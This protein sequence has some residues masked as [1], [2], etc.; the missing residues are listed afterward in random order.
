M[1]LRELNSLQDGFFGCIHTISN[2]SAFIS[3]FNGFDYG[4]AR[5]ERGREDPRHTRQTEGVDDPCG[6][7]V[8]SDGGASDYPTSLVSVIRYKE[9]RI[10]YRGSNAD[11]GLQWTAAQIQA[12]QIEK[13][14]RYGLR[15]PHTPQS[16]TWNGRKRR[17]DVFSYSIQVNCTKHPKHYELNYCRI[18]RTGAEDECTRRRGTR[19]GIRTHTTE[20]SMNAT[21]RK[22]E[23]K[24]R[25]SGSRDRR[26][27]STGGDDAR[28]GKTRN[29]KDN[30]HQRVL[31]RFVSSHPAD[32][33]LDSQKGRAAFKSG[34]V[35]HDLPPEAHTLEPAS[36]SHL[37]AFVP[38]LRQGS[39]G[40]RLDYIPTQRKGG[41]SFNPHE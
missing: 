10:S 11:L 39:R 6:P 41:L 7:V 14:F 34:A 19:A 22:R 26:M 12:T 21:K 23:T 9:C 16:C 33:F 3:I 32:E 20:T 37:C 17:S 1:V 38:D 2:C 8:K 40:S 27:L 15:K 28:Q 36:R 24:N 18:N 31:V 5:T 25:K 29:K 35:F 4:R 30:S 13:R